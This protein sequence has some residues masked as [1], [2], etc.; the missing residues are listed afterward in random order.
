MKNNT[1]K[2]FL[3]I[4]TLCFLYGCD[5][6]VPSDVVEVSETQKHKVELLNLLFLK[7]T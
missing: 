6:R 2:I 1:C 7:R 3:I 4:F 5:E